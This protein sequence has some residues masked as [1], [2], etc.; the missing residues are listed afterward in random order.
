MTPFSSPWESAGVLSP[1][2]YEEKQEEL[3]YARGE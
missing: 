2:D 1:G 3:L